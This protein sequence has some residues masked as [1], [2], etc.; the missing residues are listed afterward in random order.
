MCPRSPPLSG[1]TASLAS[2]IPYRDAKP[3]G[4]PR[5]S[6]ELF[7][8]AAHQAVLDS[9]SMAGCFSRNGEPK[10]LMPCNWPASP[11]GLMPPELSR[12]PDQRYQVPGHVTFDPG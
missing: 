10:H 12:W 2:G 4:L 1:P 5:R 6:H 9:A 7:F 11:T 8:L 3:C